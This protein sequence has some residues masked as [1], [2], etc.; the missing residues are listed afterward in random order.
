LACMNYLINEGCGL[1]IGIGLTFQPY[2][3]LPNGGFPRV[4]LWGEVTSPNNLPPPYSYSGI[5][6]FLFG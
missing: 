2:L 4:R 3:S 5:C 1:V 6:C